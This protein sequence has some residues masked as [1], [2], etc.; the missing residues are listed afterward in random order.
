MISAV[1][2]KLVDDV[3]V[4]AMH[5]HTIEARAPGHLS[6]MLKLRDDPRDFASLECSRCHEILHV[7]IGDGPSCRPQR[8]RSHRSGIVW[9]QARMRNPPAMLQLSKDA[10]TC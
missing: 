7:R 2:Q 8:R 4:G 3:A 6:T 1:A 10:P 9:E 5:F